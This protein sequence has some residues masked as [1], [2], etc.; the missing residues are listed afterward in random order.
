[1]P[2]HPPG[3]SVETES[4][5]VSTVRDLERKVLPN[6]LNFAKSRVPEQWASKPMDDILLSSDRVEWLLPMIE[7]YLQHLGRVS[8]EVSAKGAAEIKRIKGKLQ[9]IE[10]QA[11][12]LKK[13]DRTWRREVEPIFAKLNVERIEQLDDAS[14]GIVREWLHRNVEKF[15]EGEI[16]RLQGCETEN[17]SG[18][19]KNGSP[20]NSS[21][22]LKENSPQGNPR[23]DDWKGTLDLLH[24]RIEQKSLKKQVDDAQ[25]TFQ[26]LKYSLSSASKEWNAVEAEAS[27]I[28]TD[29]KSSDRR[30]EA[31]SGRNARPSSVV[32]P[33]KGEKDEE[34]ETFE[35]DVDTSVL[36][37]VTQQESAVLGIVGPLVELTSLDYIKASDLLDRLV[38][39]EK[40]LTRRLQL[41]RAES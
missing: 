6:V 19:P 41:R 33:V 24:L 10:G 14:A 4:G 34:Y 26:S 11:V 31:T 37:T 39:R 18:S 29:I 27:R 21:S 13:I 22:G 8:D 2:L 1:M 12:F 20:R 16:S 30:N 32:R 38:K 17:E 9:G 35:D 7:S 3:L 25:K 28:K 36:D 15:I 23:L 5:D 40:M